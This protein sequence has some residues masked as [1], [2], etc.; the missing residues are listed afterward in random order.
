MI[1]KYE[2]HPDTKSKHYINKNVY[3]AAKD[4]I[5]DAINLSDAQAVLFSGGKDSTAAA[6]LLRE[7]YN[8]LNINQQVNLIFMDEEVINESVVEYIKKYHD[9]PDYNV[10]WLNIPMKCGKYNTGT[11][12]DYIQND[13]RRPQI[14]KPPEYALTLEDFNINRY[15]ILDRKQI[16][17][18][19]ATLFPG[20]VCLIRGI[21]A[22][23]NLFRLTQILRRKN[24]P[25]ISSQNNKYF[26]CTPIY[27]WTQRDIFLYFYKKGIEYN[28]VYD[29]LLYGGAPLRVSTS[30]HTYNRG[31][32]NNLRKIDPP[33]YEKIV[34]TWPDMAHAD[35]YGHSKINEFENKYPH[36]LNGLIK[37][38]DDT[39]PNPRESLKF[40][41]KVLWCYKKREQNKKKPDADVFGG[42]P[43]Y[44]LFS[45]V[46]R[47]IR[48]TNIQPTDA[49][50]LN[51]YIFEGYTEK[52][53]NKDKEK[54]ERGTTK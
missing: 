13:P 9:N 34:E 31:T 37:Y 15:T 47:G 14:R 40:K 3:E 35:R 1:T 48:N 19:S 20:K 25:H 49:P 53:Y 39:Y 16:A 42:Y 44:K 43:L 30:M 45:I 28:P 22:A 7:V 18:L 10:Y 41:K 26:E 50:S 24:R 4:R 51:C 33:L 38:I 29:K 46:K 12:E 6:H 27:D 5:K 11:T 54:K 23:E 36:T 17:E 2:P 52:D 21:R 8:E 32:F